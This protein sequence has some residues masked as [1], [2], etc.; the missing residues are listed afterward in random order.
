MN[1]NTGAS[2]SSCWRTVTSWL[3]GTFFGVNV[4]IVVLWVP[5]QLRWICHHLCGG[6]GLGFPSRSKQSVCHVCWLLQSDMRDACRRAAGQ[7]CAVP[8]FDS[9][10]STRPASDVCRPAGMCVSFHQTNSLASSLSLITNRPE[11]E[12]ESLCS[13]RLGW[14]LLW[15]TSPTP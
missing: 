1:W 14:K 12:S 3:Q 13:F 7:M 6:G 10:T 15:I 11:W 4:H 2:V 5:F 8:P 9:L